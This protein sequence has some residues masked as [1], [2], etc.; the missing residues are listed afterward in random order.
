MT[1]Q[2]SVDSKWLDRGDPIG[3]PETV[4]DCAVS[5]PFQGVA[6]SVA[7]GLLTASGRDGNLSN[8]VPRS[9]ISYYVS[10][11]AA[12]RPVRPYP[13]LVIHG[14]QASAKSTLESGI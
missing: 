4:A 5:L 1:S 2:R 14:E 13:I 3:S 7:P 6:R 11:A 8:F 10:E 9:T 12:V